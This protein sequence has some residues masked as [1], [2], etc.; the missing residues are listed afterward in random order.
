MIR[1]AFSMDRGRQWGSMICVI[2]SDLSLSLNGNSDVC[3]CMIVHQIFLLYYINS[4]EIE[5]SVI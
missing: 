4:Q 3:F 2:S 5:E 1:R